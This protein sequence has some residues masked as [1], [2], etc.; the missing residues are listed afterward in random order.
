MAHEL[1]M[2]ADG[3]LR[4]TIAGDLDRSVIDTLQGDYRSFLE[5][6]TPAAPLNNILFTARV[7]RISSAA[8][9]FFTELTNDPRFGSAAIIDP[10]RR[11]RV[12]GKFI[13][14]ATGREN[15]HYFNSEEEALNW[16][17]SRV[18]LFEST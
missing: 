7:G 11:V 4:T 2:K 5:A 18:G 13:L 14:K 10:P 15:I 9:R 3:I 17:K 16:L 8:R 1:S 6:S 12:L